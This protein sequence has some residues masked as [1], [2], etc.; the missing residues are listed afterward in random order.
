MAANKSPSAFQVADTYVALDDACGARPLA[1]TPDFWKTLAEDRLGEFSRLVSHGQIDRD[2]TTWE[3]H[4]AGEEI[5]M[6]L[7][8][9]VEL[10]LETAGG[11]ERVVLEHAG[12]FVLVPRDTW[13]TARVL[14][15]ARLLFITPG[16]GTS[17]R[18][19]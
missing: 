15:P 3:K 1:V 16:A 10:L 18:P 17:H 7:D 9:A 13:H 8:G 2:W 4:P 6:L 19:V 5:V 11:C 14:R 12:A